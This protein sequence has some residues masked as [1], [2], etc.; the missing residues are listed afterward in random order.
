MCDSTCSG[1]TEYD[2]SDSRTSKPL[3]ETFSLEYDNGSK[4]TGDLYQDTVSIAGLNATSQTLGVVIPPSL[5]SP[6]V[7]TANAG[8]ILWPRFYGVCFMFT[9]WHQLTLCE[10]PTSHP[11]V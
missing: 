4:V 3:G 2:P 8:Y 10:A 6:V 5:S 11:M 9:D 1:H 7:L